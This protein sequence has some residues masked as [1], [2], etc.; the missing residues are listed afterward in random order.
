MANNVNDVEFDVFKFFG[1]QK[2]EKFLGKNFYF[3]RDDVTKGDGTKVKGFAWVEV[4]PG[5][6][7]TRKYKRLGYHED[8]NETARTK[9]QIEAMPEREGEL[10]MYFLKTGGT[11]DRHLVYIDP[12]TG[13]TIEEGETRATFRFHGHH[14]KAAEMRVLVNKA[15][16]A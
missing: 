10:R 14:G 7:A 13:S 3:T 11:V 1:N 9:T 5:S 15:P 2:H 6:S 4:E 8:M 12:T 16:K